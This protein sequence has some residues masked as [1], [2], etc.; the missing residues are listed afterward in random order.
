MLFVSGVVVPGVFV[1]GVVVPGVMFETSSANSWQN[2]L[3]ASTN[4][5]T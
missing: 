2:F 1:P 5:F 4:C 3:I